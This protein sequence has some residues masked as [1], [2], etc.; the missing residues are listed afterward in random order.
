[1]PEVKQNISKA[2]YN[3]YFVR[4]AEKKLSLS[5][6]KFMWFKEG[7]FLNP[8]KKDEHLK[9]FINEE[10]ENFYEKD[11]FNIPQLELCL[12]TKCTLK[13]K[14]CCALIP[15]LDKEKHSEMT[16][17]EF[18]ESID[19]L[20]NA[21]NNIQ[22][23]VI[24]GGEPLINANLP[25]MLDYAAQKEK[26][27]FIQLITNGTMLPS[28]KLLNTLKNNNKKIYVYIS[29]YSGNEELTPILKHE[30]IKE[31]LKE[32]DIK[33]QKPENWPWSKEL[34]FA[35][36]KFDTEVTTKKFIECHRTK[37]NQILNGKLDICSKATAAREMNL[38]E[39]NDTVDILNS[40]N[41][42]EDLINFYQKEYCDACE[43][44]IV[45]QEEVQPALQL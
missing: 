43:Y 45:S 31:L 20:C 40:T 42:R 26:I 4:N 24:L 17:E 6:M 38:F 2:F 12:T 18:K 44:C 34:G 21:V 7:K 13:C 22:H 3:R 15:Q 19:K 33:L 30:K 10:I 14:D 41:L 23:L 39:I 11:I 9:N 32:N 8:L 28:E 36:E 1:M 37:C 29:N 5:L 27:F 16:V 35:K 25:E